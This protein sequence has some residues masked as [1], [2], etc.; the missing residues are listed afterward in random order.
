MPLPTK[1]R[2]RKPAKDKSIEAVLVLKDDW[3]F[4]ASN[5]I[6]ELIALKRGLNGRG[7][8]TYMLPPGKV[9]QPP[10]AKVTTF[11]N[12]LSQKYRTLSTNALEIV[13]KQDELAR[14]KAQHQAKSRVPGAPAAPA[15]PGEPPHEA[16]P[17]NN[18]FSTMMNTAAM[19]EYELVAEATNP[20]SRGWFKFKNLLS[21][22][23]HVKQKWQILNLTVAAVKMAKNVQNS[24]VSG[25]ATREKLSTH[26]EE[27]EKIINEMGVYMDTLVDAN[28]PRKGLLT[29]SDPLAV[30]LKFF[31]RE[32]DSAYNIG[33]PQ[34]RAKFL[35]LMQRFTK[36][37]NENEK[38]T[39]V[40]QMKDLHTRVLA[41]FKEKYPLMFKGTIY[42][43]E[44]DLPLTLSKPTAADLIDNHIAD[45][46]LSGEPSDGLQTPGEM[47]HDEIGV[48]PSEPANQFAPGNL[49][50]GW[51][52]KAPRLPS[53]E[54]AAY[55]ARSNPP[56]TELALTSVLPDA[57]TSAQV[58]TAAPIVPA[59]S[60][61]KGAKFRESKAN[62]T[63]AEIQKIAHN[64]LTRWLKKKLLDLPFSGK[65]ALF[66]IRIYDKITVL[67]HDLDSLMDSIQAGESLDSLFASYSSIKKS[68]QPIKIDK[69]NLMGLD[70]ETKKEVIKPAK[71][72]K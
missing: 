24:A 25:K 52:Q 33:Y 17:S 34:L 36:A 47:V 20:L 4:Q 43:L 72:K 56:S 22:D 41:I 31:Q 9:T 2:R 30:E 64:L 53:A 59:K 48:Q 32:F 38:S 6:N 46:A 57:A 49:P 67:I 68:L 26:F 8:P 44:M 61:G 37:T 39:T 50:K 65:T 51:S 15:A 21:R 12:Q 7:D 42:Q 62:E 10:N 40:D 29:H 1:K 71:T 13:K 35:H 14:E 18:P 55:N 28:D 45:R 58:P 66:R 5:F 63:Q 3:N 11:L 60:K 54:V 19:Y 23:P 27:L 69:S 16:T 70:Q